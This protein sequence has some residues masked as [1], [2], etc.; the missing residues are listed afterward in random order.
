MFIN[1][2]TAA[3]ALALLLVDSGAIVAQRSTVAAQGAAKSQTGPAKPGTAPAGAQKPPERKR[4][5][6]DEPTKRELGLSAD[7][8][9]TLDQIFSQTKDELA[10]Y[11]ESVQRESKELDR[12]IVESKAEQWFVLRQ[13]EKTEAA[14]S[15][16][17]KLR[18]MT[19]YR[20]HRVLTPAQRVKLQ[21]IQ[22]RDR[23]DPRKRP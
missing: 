2:L 3:A 19:L 16:L 11:A 12:L 10:G 23:K 17:N 7:Q 15:N 21:A 18:L 8:A 13:I 14:R 6:S 20:M 1:K 5:W 22:D 4:W 9:K